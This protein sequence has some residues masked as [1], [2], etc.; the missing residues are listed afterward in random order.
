MFEIGD[1]QRALADMVRKFAAEK[2]APFAVQWDEERHLPLD[3]IRESAELGLGGMYVCEESGGSGLSR[4][5]AVL[6]FE[7]L[8]R[9]CPALSA[10][11]SIHNM[12]AWMIDEY[13]S[14][15]QKERF[16]PSLLGLEHIASYCLS[17]PGCGSDAAALSTR[18]RREGKEYVLNGVKQFISGAGSNQIYLVMARTG[19]PEDGA[20]G[21]SC[22]IIEKG[23]PGLSFGPQEKKMGWHIQPTAQVIMEECRVSE[24]NLL[25]EEGKGFKIAMSGLDGGR[26]NIAACSLG[27]AREAF[28]RALAYCGERKA[29]GK[30]LGDF[31]SMRFKLA[32]METALEAARLILYAAAQKLDAKKRD[33]SKACAM[34][35][36]WVTDTGS[37][38]ADDALQIH[39]GYGYLRE[40]GIEKI[41]RDL[42]VH[43]I[44]EGTNEIMRLIIGRELMGKDAQ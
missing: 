8:A 33:A 22:F 26:L 35:K 6:A 15:K 41:V 12:A 1:D 21:I 36:L 4:L 28:E 30:F 14:D 17:E 18:A 3:A 24:D 7:A 29:F 34:A 37:Q 16:L 31:Q 27:G 19:E 43:R 40:Y 32:E 13:G 11:L 23:A 10:F 38:V 5:D 9:G 20:N 44:L 25:G 39:G 42:R 2:I